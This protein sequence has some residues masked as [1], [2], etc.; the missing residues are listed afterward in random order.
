MSPEGKHDKRKWKVR[1]DGKPLIKAWE[2]NRRSVLFGNR[3]TNMILQIII[4]LYKSSFS[5]QESID[6]S[7]MDGYL[8]S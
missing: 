4:S 1:L 3:L 6:V 8:T 2:Y 5:V 7:Y